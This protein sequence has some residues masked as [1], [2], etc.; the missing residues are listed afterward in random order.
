MLLAD[1][2]RLFI[3][4]Y[5]SLYCS[6]IVGTLQITSQSLSHRS[7]HIVG[8]GVGKPNPGW[9]N[10]S[11]LLPRVKIGSEFHPTFYSLRI[12]GLFHGVKWSERQVITRLYPE[13]SSTTSGPILLLPHTP[14]RHAHGQLQHSPTLPLFPRP[15]LLRYTLSSP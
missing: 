6:W 9:S 14:S 7:Q 10:G 1:T 4:G 2:S 11:F 15:N 12:G 13:S 3:S 8:Q 5:R